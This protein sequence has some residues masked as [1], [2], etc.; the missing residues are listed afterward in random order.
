MPQGMDMQTLLNALSQAQPQG[1]GEVDVLA[2]NLVKS[3]DPNLSVM[4][5]KR[6]FSFHD[7]IGVDPSTALGAMQYHEGNRRGSIDDII[8]LGTY[9]SNPKI[10]RDPLTSKL[11]EIMFRNMMPEN[12][13]QRESRLGRES[14]QDET[15]D[16]RRDIEAITEGEAQRKKATGLEKFHWDA[17]NPKSKNPGGSAS[18]WNRDSKGKTVLIND[19]RDAY[20]GGGI[21]PRKGAFIEAPLPE[22]PGKGQMTSDIFE[23]L[24]Q[25]NKKKDETPAEFYMDMLKEIEKTKGG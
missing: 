19:Y 24:Y 1:G 21:V 14:Y 5:P 20:W 10:R 6:D 18:A 13:A 3:A 7:M 17:T 15:L 22:I 4:A 23:Y 25:Q 16:I 9:L 11:T 2:E 8:Q 12:A